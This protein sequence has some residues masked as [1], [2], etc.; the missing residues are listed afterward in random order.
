MI[1]KYKAA[2]AYKVESF[3]TIRTLGVLA[4]AWFALG[5]AVGVFVLSV[6]K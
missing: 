6:S 5:F 3:W 4:A 1:T 2:K